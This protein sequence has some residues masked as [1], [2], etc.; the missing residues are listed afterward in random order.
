MTGV[1][2]EGD[3]VMEKKNIMYYLR[4]RLLTYHGLSEL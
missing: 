4:A 2:I 3:K 1:E